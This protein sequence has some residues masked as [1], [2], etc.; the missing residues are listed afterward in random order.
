MFKLS[1][2]PYIIKET[3][4]VFF[5]YKPDGYTSDHSFIEINKNG[6]SIV[7]YVKNNLSIDDNLKNAKYRYGQ[8][9]RLDYGTN[10]TIII[11]RNIATFERIQ[12]Y[13]QK[14]NKKTKKVYIALVDGKIEKEHDFIVLYMQKI[15]TNGE[16]T[17]S[18]DINNKNGEPTLS[19]YNVWQYLHDD[20]TNKYFTLVMVRIY[21]G[22]THQIRVHMKSIGHSLVNDY[23][24]GQLNEKINNGK[25]FL[26]SYLYCIKDIGCSIDYKNE[27]NFT[28]NELKIT[29]KINYLTCIQYLLKKNNDRTIK[30]KE[31]KKIIKKTNKRL[32]VYIKQTENYTIVNIPSGKLNEVDESIRHKLKNNLLDN[33]LH[34]VGIIDTSI[35]V[36]YIYFLLARRKINNME[37]DKMKISTYK[38]LQIKNKQ[39]FTYTYTQIIVEPKIQFSSFDALIDELNKNNIFLIYDK[40]NGKN[41]IEYTVFKHFHNYELPIID[42]HIIHKFWLNNI[43]KNKYKY[44]MNI[45]FS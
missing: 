35:H 39:N 33:K 44:D 2:A 13:M 32:T 24:Y 21:T 31:F 23:H 7:N 5:V 16:Y 40:K 10:G 12:Q 19:E 29:H 17:I 22:M 30:L 8:I 37:N 11:A 26:I 41:E 18:Y 43:K 36:K 15:Y 25:M 38:T 28:F 45:V 42:T 3:K 27:P 4:D 1:N 9:N 34:T 6:K 14:Q 20:K